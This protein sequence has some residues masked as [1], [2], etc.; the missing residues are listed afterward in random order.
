MSFTTAARTK[1]LTAIFVTLLVFAGAPLATAQVQSVD[2]NSALG[3]AQQTAAK[4]A[5]KVP[6]QPQE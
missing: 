2:P 4:Q 3:A 5:P 6:T 1:A